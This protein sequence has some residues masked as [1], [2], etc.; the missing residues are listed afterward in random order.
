MKRFD[1]GD[2]FDNKDDDDKYLNGF[3]M[4]GGKHTPH[5]YT[6][7]ISNMLIFHWF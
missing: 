6:S 1:F 3:T 2:G 5:E 4:L 7:A